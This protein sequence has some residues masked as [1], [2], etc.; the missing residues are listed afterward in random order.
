MARKKK[1]HRVLN[2]KIR[3]D[4][5]EMLDVYC[6]ETGINKTFVTEKAL[7]QYLKKQKKAVENE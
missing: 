3:R 5:W 2:C 1:E 6:S 7:E 4:V